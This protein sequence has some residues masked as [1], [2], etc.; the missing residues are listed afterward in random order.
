MFASIF[1]RAAAVAVLA[2]SPAVAQEAD[3]DLPEFPT[4]SF[5]DGAL[6]AEISVGEITARVTI[7]KMPEDDPD[8]NFP[9]LHVLVDDREVLRAIGAGADL[10]EPSAEAS[11]AEMDSSNDTP[12]V[13]FT[14]YSGGAHCCSRT[15]VAT[16]TG[17]GWKAVNVGEFDSDGGY[18]ED[19]DGDGRAEIVLADNRFLYRF[20][21]YSCSAAPLM[22][23]SVENGAVVDRS[24]D[25]RFRE[26]HE[27]WLQELEDGSDA[28][29]RWRSPGFLAGWVATRIRLGEGKEA[30]QELID[31]WDSASDEGALACTNGADLQKCAR[32]D[33]KVLKFPDRLKLFLSANGYGF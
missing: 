27:Q 11:I 20:D 32:R 19:A 13:Y 17:L 23:L 15:I 28:I 7:E 8:L 29:R 26:V 10:D 9:V 22:V 25:P 3:E 6:S 5:E 33:R 18:I 31:R 14:S 1:L 4:T 30:W 12:E 21:C 24:S 16:K 2:V